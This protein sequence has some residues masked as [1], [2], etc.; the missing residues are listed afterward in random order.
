MSSQKEPTASV[1]NVVATRGY[2]SR[3]DANYMYFSP[4]TIL[5]NS[6]RTVPSIPWHTKHTA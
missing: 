2:F 3:S 4:M 5:K 6:E 1:L